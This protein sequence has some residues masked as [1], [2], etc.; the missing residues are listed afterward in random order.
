MTILKRISVTKEQISIARKTDLYRFLLEEHSSEVYREGNSI[1]LRNNRSI[2]IKIGYFG[3]YDF[4]DSSSGNSIDCL[5]KHFGYTFVEAVK[6]LSERSSNKSELPCEESENASIGKFE[7]FSN[8]SRN[9]FA[10]LM[11]IRQ[12]PA[13]V[14][15]K[16][17]NDRLIFQEEK[18]NNIV[19]VNQDENFAEI[20]GTKSFGRT[21]HG[22]AK[23]SDKSAFW[24]FKSYHIDSAVRKVFICESAIDAIS[25]HCLHQVE[26]FTP[27][28]MYC[29]IAGV[30]NQQKIDSIKSCVDS[31]VILAVD[32]DSAGEKCRERNSD[33]KAEIPILKDWNEDWCKLVQE[34]HEGKR[35]KKRYDL[36]A[37]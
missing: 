22:I 27:N 2:S 21:F 18:Y 15:Y 16:L 30:S 14:I 37:Q 9:M 8:G 34:I 1:R 7:R 3:Y 5:V 32:N 31:E 17:I 4:A 19:F 13:K 24:A 23:G 6:A 12:I 20:H 36:F 26:N 29:S 28:Y 35:A 10:Y 25:L 33:L 11:K